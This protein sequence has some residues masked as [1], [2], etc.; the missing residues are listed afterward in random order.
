MLLEKISY[1]EDFPLRIIIASITEYPVHYH[2][3]IEFIYILKGH[4]KL[5]N[6]YCFYTLR[7]GDIFVNAGH[8]V[9]GMENIGEE[10]NI[11]VLIQISTR[12]FSQYFP[13]LGKACYRTYSRTAADSR[14]DRLREMLL[15]LVLQFQT[16]G[17]GYKEQ[18]IRLMKDMIDYLNRYFNLFTFESGIAVNAEDIDPVSI[19]RISR[20]INYIYQNYPEKI[21]LED[22]EKLEHLSP[23]YLSH[24]IRDYTGMNFREFL[25]FARVERSEILL[26]DTEKKISQIA[27]EV[28]F[29]TTAYYEKYF[30]RWFHRTPAAHRAYYRPL[31]MGPERPER[32]TEI[33][34]E[35]GIPLLRAM[36][37]SL[38]SQ[39]NR[40]SISRHTVNIHVAGAEQEAEAAP[41]WT[42]AIGW[43]FRSH[44]K[45]SGHWAAL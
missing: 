42:S 8:E 18:C 9:H 10:E 1:P 15:H 44:R 29:S 16:R 39:K 31:V 21:R 22:L 7:Q 26:L 33:G 38:T 11:A 37:S 43:K 6:G 23:F 25:C 12:Y 14:L 34:A 27:R 19:G 30:K 17:F 32:V 2:R 3:D 24:I 4:V 36:L 5:K 28:G 13:D 40:P 35:R 41:I 20:I 45:M